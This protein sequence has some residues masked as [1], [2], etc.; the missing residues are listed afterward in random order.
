MRRHRAIPTITSKGKI[1]INPYSAAGNCVTAG[2]QKS[3]YVDPRP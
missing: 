2:G 3:Q 1:Y